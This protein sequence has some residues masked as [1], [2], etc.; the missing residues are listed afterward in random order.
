MHNSQ[1]KPQNQL[2]IGNNFI[3]SMVTFHKLVLKVFQSINDKLHQFFVHQN[4]ICHGY[5]SEHCKYTL[6]ENLYCKEVKSTKYFA[7][8]QGV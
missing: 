5:I 2:K 4:S 3:L 8:I 6:M 1:T 7:I